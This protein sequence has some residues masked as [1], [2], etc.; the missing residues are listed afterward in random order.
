[1]IRI[2]HSVSNMDRAGIE[3]MLMN[4]YRNI[5]RNEIQFDFLCNKKK[6][7]AYDD[8]IISMGGRIFRST[9]LNPFKYFKYI[10]Y[11]KN[12]FEENPEYK[13]VHAHNGAFVVYPLFAAKLN[14]I[15]IRISH[16]H[17]AAFI[18]DYK[19]PLKVLCRSLIP[20]CTNNKWAC[21]R[22]ASKF[23]YGKKATEK[24]EIKIINNAID[25][26][27]FIFDVSV[28]KKM[29]E[30]YDLDNK[31]VIGHVG[32]FMS[33]KNHSFLIDIFYEIHKINNSA[34]LILLGDGELEGEIK[35]K[36]TE[37]GIQDAVMFMGNVNNVNEWYQ[38]MDAFVLPS[39]SEG[40]PVVGV[41]AQAAGLPCAFSDGVTDE[42]GILDSSVFLSRKLP[43]RKWAETILEITKDHKRIDCGS[44]MTKAGYDIK[45]E[46]KKLEAEYKKMYRSLN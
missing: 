11:M 45:T 21:S 38:A 15:P 40:L 22:A 10:K 24:G 23:Y 43:A 29:R 17:S 14:H 5:D 36:V 2:L 28:R 16:M 37:L 27:K 33:E 8:E 13:I 6:P 1:M 18:Y 20:F 31:V 39:I 3:T 25:V 4:Y 32:R 35:R 42:I 19:W 9:G 34:V 44:K 12:L 26:E 7:G 30:K 41:E 46:A